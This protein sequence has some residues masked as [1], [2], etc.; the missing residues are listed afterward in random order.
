MHGMSPRR[1]TAVRARPG[2]VPR[3]VPSWDDVR[4]FLAIHRAGSLSSAAGPL[5]LSQPTCGR[6]LA[7]LEAALGMRLF[8]RTPEGLHLTADGAAL[9]QPAEAMEAG[10]RALALETAGRGR[11]L[12]G[13]VRIATT[14]LL[15]VSFLVEALRALRASHPEIRFELVLSNEESDLLRREADV[16]LRFVPEGTRPRPDRL[17]AQKLGD[18]PFDLYG[19]EAYLA[20]RGTPPD[21]AALAGHDVVVTSARHPASAWCAS[22]FRGANVV[23]AVPSMLV[24]SAAVASGLGLGVIPRRAASRFP[25]L[26]RLLPDVAR[27]TGWLVVN[28]ELRR[29]I[30]I[31][32]VADSLAAMF[33]RPGAG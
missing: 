12:Q 8:E 30:R 6:R 2:E 22:A 24:S 19:A 23:V 31:R 25:E 9:V 10:A 1:R 20:A 21:P 15:A 18:E 17:V 14:E 11:D 27:G 13:V 26:R 4:V 3:S 5:G 29:M 16:A 32:V 28:P 33:R 7:G